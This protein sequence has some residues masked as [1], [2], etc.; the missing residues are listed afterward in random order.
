[1]GKVYAIVV[2][3]I[4][5]EQNSIYKLFYSEEKAKEISDKLNKRQID[6][7]IVSDKLH[8]KEIQIEDV[9]NDIANYNIEDVFYG[10]IC[11]DEKYITELYDSFKSDEERR[12]FVRDVHPEEF[13]VE[14]ME[15]E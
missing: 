9:L 1:M 6:A 12:K 4:E 14:E 7:A 2:N 13:W 11:F 3:D 10:P 5:F 8:K 15:V